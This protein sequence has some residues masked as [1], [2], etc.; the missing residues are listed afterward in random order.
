MAFFDVILCYR[1][2]CIAAWYYID[3]DGRAAAVLSAEVV[4]IWS[5]FIALLLDWPVVHELI[6][7]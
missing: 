6:L 7:N 1:C 2:L 4:M 5:E 3:I